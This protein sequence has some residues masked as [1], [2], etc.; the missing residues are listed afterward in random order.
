MASY[1][2]MISDTFMDQTSAKTLREK[3]TAN[4]RSESNLVRDENGIENR[5]ASRRVEVKFRLKDDEMIQEL[6]QILS[7]GGGETAP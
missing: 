6:S 7:S 5:D 3:L 2:L 4:G 1:L